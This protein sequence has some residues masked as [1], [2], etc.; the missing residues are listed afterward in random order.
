MVTGMTAVWIALLPNTNHPKI[1]IFITQR[2]PLPHPRLP[3][4]LLQF[5]LRVSYRLL[6]LLLQAFLPA[7]LIPLRP[8]TL[9]QHNQEIPLIPMRRTPSEKETADELKHQT[10]NGPTSLNSQCLLRPGV[11]EVAEGF[12]ELDF[13]YSFY[14]RLFP[15][16]KIP[17]FLIHLS[18]WA[19]VIPYIFVGCCHLY[20]S[21]QTQEPP[22]FGTWYRSLLNISP[23]SK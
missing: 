6:L 16:P 22:F 5:L 21:N 19:S 18:Y 4:R 7:Q 23:T 1:T 2:P 3:P 15:L 9:Q 11:G 14:I 8:S 12:A 17:L 20:N 13:F 10:L